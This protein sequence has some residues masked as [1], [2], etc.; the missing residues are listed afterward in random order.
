MAR[1]VDPV[2]FLRAIGGE[3]RHRAE[4]AGLPWPA[5]LGLRVDGKKF[6][7]SIRRQGVTATARHLGRSYLRLNVADFTRLVLGHLDWSRALVDGRVEAST[8]IALKTARTLFPPVPFWR[9]ALDEL[10]A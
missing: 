5:E 1:L 10:S 3:L 2:K 7:L 8:Q 4:V 6:R 9:P